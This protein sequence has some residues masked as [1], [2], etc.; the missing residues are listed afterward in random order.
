[1]LR[2]LGNALGLGKKTFKIGEESANSSTMSTSSS[3]T[4]QG[5]HAVERSPHGRVRGK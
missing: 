4:G 1:M 5:Y 3:G 2:M